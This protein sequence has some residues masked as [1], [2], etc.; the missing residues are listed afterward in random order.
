MG[1]QRNSNQFIISSRKMFNNLHEGIFFLSLAE[2]K[3]S[4][5][6]KTKKYFNIK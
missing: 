1:V 2:L 5:N 3:Q 6:W 4:V